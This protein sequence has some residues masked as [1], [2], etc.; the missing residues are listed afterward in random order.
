MRITRRHELKDWEWSVTQEGDLRVTSRVGP[1]P[2]ELLLHPWEA[3]PGAT[4]VVP[5]NVARPV[6]CH[7]RLVVTG[8]EIRVDLDSRWDFLKAILK[9][10]IEHFLG[11]GGWKVTQ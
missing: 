6:Q 1:L 5:F 11:S 4:C 3:G 9:P 10:V 2:V 7:G 8:E